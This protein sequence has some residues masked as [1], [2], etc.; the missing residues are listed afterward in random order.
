MGRFLASVDPG[1]GLVLC[2][3]AVRA[4]ETVEL[5]LEA[6]ALDLPVE[7]DRGLYLPPSADML[8]RLRKVDDGI[9]SVLLVSHEP[10]SSALVSVLTGGAPPRFPTAAIARIALGCASWSE[11]AQEAGRLE[12][13]VTPRLLQAAGD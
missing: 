10:S 3:S 4:R 11:L 9:R 5:A 6:G 8:A 13:L 2:S 1:L 7:I 12:W